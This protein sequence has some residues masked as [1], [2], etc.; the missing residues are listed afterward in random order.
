MHA[1]RLNEGDVLLA[2]PAQPGGDA[3]ARATA[4]DDDDPMVHRCPP[5]HWH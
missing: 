1:G 4:P 2:G 3:D 5:R